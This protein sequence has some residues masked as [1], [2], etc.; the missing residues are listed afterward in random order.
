M[1]NQLYIHY[2]YSTW[3]FFWKVEG[4]ATVK[5]EPGSKSAAKKHIREAWF[6]N[7]KHPIA[8][9]WKVKIYCNCPK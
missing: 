1:S 4:D 8:F 6:H 2:Y 3:P 7:K 5:Y 9:M